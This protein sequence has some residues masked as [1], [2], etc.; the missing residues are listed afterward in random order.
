MEGA[1]HEHLLPCCALLEDECFV[2]VWVAELPAAQGDLDNASIVDKRDDAGGH[3]EGKRSCCERRV[4]GER[5]KSG[6]VA[7][8]EDYELD[9]GP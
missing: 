4:R 6:Y 8:A 9:E 5:M 7:G 2:G 1:A 3:S